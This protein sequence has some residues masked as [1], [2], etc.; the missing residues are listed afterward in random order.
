M[1]DAF[2]ASQKLVLSR[3]EGMDTKGVQG[4]N[5]LVGNS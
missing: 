5:Q 3:S 4:A 1:Y 2:S